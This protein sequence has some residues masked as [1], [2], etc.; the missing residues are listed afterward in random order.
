MAQY[1]LKQSPP[2]ESPAHIFNNI[3]RTCQVGDRDVLCKIH[4]IFNLCLKSKQLNSNVCI[5]YVDIF[6]IVTNN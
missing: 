2:F 5:E 1:F 3:Q 6:K 4:F